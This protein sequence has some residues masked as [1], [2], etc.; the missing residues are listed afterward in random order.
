M[1]TGITHIDGDVWLNSSRK[2]E[3]L[4]NPAF[5]SFLFSTH[6]TTELAI[7]HIFALL[8]ITSK[9]VNT[10]DFSVFMGAR[11]KGRALSELNCGVI[12]CGRIGSRLANILAELSLKVFC[13]DVFKPIN[14]NKKLI[15]TESIDEL[16]SCSDLI[17]IAADYK[18]GSKIILD[19]QFFENMDSP[20]YIVNIARA[21]LV[22]YFELENAIRNQILL[23]YA[24]DVY[25]QENHPNKSDYDRLYK[26]KTEG[27]NINLTPHIGGNTIDAHNK[28][29]TVAK[30]FIERF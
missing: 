12:G 11:P 23:G 28:L 6:S 20:K 10:S 30:E 26:L 27:F 1:T 9:I 15:Y 19:K 5:K 4:K 25:Y 17:V 13:T 3:T 2:I 21:E 29:F 24:T 18:L 14:L 16:I 8:R 7:Y 22:D